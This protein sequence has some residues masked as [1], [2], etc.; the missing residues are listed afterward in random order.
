ML[1][2]SSAL[3]VNRLAEHPNTRQFRAKSME[4]NATFMNKGHQ[5]TNDPFPNHQI[6][7][8]QIPLAYQCLSEPLV[9]A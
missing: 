1:I 7:G 9:D 3:E 2:L 4:K 5:W 6:V 8:S